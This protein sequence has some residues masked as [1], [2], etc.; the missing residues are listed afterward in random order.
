MAQYSSLPVSEARIKA[1]TA[2]KKALEIEPDLAEAHS[3]LAVIRDAFDRDW[4]SAER[5]YKRAIELDPNDSTAHET[6]SM[7]LAAMGN[8]TQGMAEAKRALDL[9]PLSLRVNAVICWQYYFARQYDQAVE[10]AQKTL[11]LDS[12]YMPA[13]WCAGVSHQKKG[14]SGQAVAELQKTVALAGNTESRAWLAYVYAAIGQ[15]QKALEILQGL[16]ALSKR[17]HV[18]PYQIAEIYTGLGDMDHA[19]EW[20]NKAQQ[21]GFDYIYLTAWPANDALR[22]DVRYKQL[23]ERIGLPR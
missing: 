2:T 13:H 8:S 11:E 6:Y 3:T 7:Y 17:E 22:T 15:Q 5:E 20:W 18:S 9:D 10:A 1:E 14:D 16:L 21:E 23:L 12:N 4:T 19:F